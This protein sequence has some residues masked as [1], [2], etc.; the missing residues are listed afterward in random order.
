[1]QQIES[2]GQKIAAEEVL[3]QKGAEIAD[4]DVMIDGRPTGIHAD[5]SIS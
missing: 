1:M 3:K 5:L 4:V 2:L